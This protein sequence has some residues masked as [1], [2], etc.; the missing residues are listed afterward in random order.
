MLAER[1]TR[2]DPKVLDAFVDQ[3]PRIEK[4][5]KAYSDS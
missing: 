3:I 5:R 4:I 2:F 1:G